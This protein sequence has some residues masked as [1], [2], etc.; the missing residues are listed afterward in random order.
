MIGRKEAV[1]AV[2]DGTNIESIILIVGKTPKWFD[3]TRQENMTIPMV[4]TD[5]KRPKPHDSDFV[6]EQLVQ[7]I[8]GAGA[9]D[10]MFA[11][12]YTNVHNAKP[13]AIVALDS[14]GEIYVG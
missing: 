10:K 14:Q 5:G 13:K 2:S 4:Y 9:T 12:W 1:M 3:P 8:H 11:D 7:V 6:A